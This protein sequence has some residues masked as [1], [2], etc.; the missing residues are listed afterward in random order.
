MPSKN[1]IPAR[2][3]LCLL[4]SFLISLFSASCAFAL[5][6]DLNGDASINWADLGL[7]SDQWLNTSGTADFNGSGRVDS[8]DYA[9]LAGNWLKTGVP[10]PVSFWKLDGNAADSSGSGHNGTGSET[11]W[12]SG[13]ICDGAAL[14]TDPN[15]ST[16]ATHDYISVP[17]AG[18]T[19]AAGTVALWVNST[20]DA[21]NVYYFGHTADPTGFTHRIQI[22][23]FAKSGTNPLRIGFG[24]NG[25]V[26]GDLTLMTP[27]TWFHLALT[28]TGT[29]GSGTCTVYVN[30]TSA[31]SAAYSS[32]SALGNFAHIGNSGQTVANGGC[33]ALID[34]VA[35]WSQALNAS[36]MTIVYQ[37]CSFTT[38]SAAAGPSPAN[39]AAAVS[40]ASDLSWTAGSGADS[41][42]VCFGTV[43]PPPFVVNQ[44]STTYDPG[45]MA[46]GTTYY[47]RITEKNVFGKTT[48]SVWQFTTMTAPGKT[49]NP[50]PANS[51]SDVSITADLGW[52]AGS[53]ATNYD[54]YFGTANP[55]PFAAN[56]SV[57]SYQ[58]PVANY[59]TQYY[60]RIDA[61]N[62]V[63]R[64]TGDLWSFTTAAPSP[65]GKASNP[66]PANGSANVAISTGLAWTAGSNA[67]SHDVYF[68]TANPPAFKT[69]TTNNSYD[70]GTLTLSA[71]YYWR[72]DAKNTV[73]T[74]AGDL[75]S[76]TTISN[77]Q[78]TKATNLLPLNGTA[79]YGL[80]MNLIWA[81]GQNVL[82][83]DVYIGT[84]NPPAFKANV[85]TTKYNPGPLTVGTV[86]YWRINEVNGAGTAVGDIWQ[87]TTRPASSSYT[88]PVADFFAIPLSGWD[89][90]Y[91]PEFISLSTGYITNYI[92]EYGDG[93]YS[94]ELAPHHQYA[95]AGTYTITL[96]VSGP[97]GESTWTRTGYIT[98]KDFET[99]YIWPDY[100]V[101][102]PT[103]E[104]FD[105]ALNAVEDSQTP[106]LAA[107]DPVW[108]GTGFPQ[109]FS[110]CPLFSSFRYPG[111][112]SGIT[113]I[114]SIP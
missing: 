107:G 1:N 110:K 65:A 35:V 79:N 85:T 55:P 69:N 50:S 70:S 34:N 16:K 93:T 43:D 21:D 92:W 101:A 29:G 36:Q 37:N 105:A 64:A 90:Y 75:W 2:I 45:T 54:V 25:N 66:N 9:S 89:I 47:W 8:I 87:F 28:W 58:L 109:S 73:G 100:I 39:G 33:R 74:T 108:C 83:H 4:V 103:Q 91:Q 102:E 13:G 57:V 11:E 12:S 67:E 62:A 19:A 14:F 94:T 10:A 104:A 84:A 95:Q 22:K 71:T 86:Y 32:F 96:N 42:D 18:M 56:V 17:T 27:G 38:P 24:G 48:G 88:A 80:N 49:F 46:A 98:V 23:N 113:P 99:Q 63:G 53:N 60:W 31:G 81:A 111:R 106:G 51:A 20:S 40:P 3:K 68:G 61:I 72:I 26:F 78:P 5:E 82:S 77:I 97:G 30:G 6:G 114:S 7:F 41:H 52:S 76:F 112:R 15:I 44:T 59:S